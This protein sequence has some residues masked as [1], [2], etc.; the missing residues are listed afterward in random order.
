MLSFWTHYPTT[1]WNGGGCIKLWGCFSLAQTGKPVRVDGKMDK[2]G[3]IQEK[4][5][6]EAKKK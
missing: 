2:H 1:L 3:M 6:L 4:N 5:L